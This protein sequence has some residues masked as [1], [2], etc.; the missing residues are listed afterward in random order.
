[1][2]RLQSLAAVLLAALAAVAPA[3]AQQAERQPLQVFLTCNTRCDLDFLRTEL[4]YLE[5][6]RDRADADVHVL[7]SDIET[8][9]GGEQY[10]LWFI[11]LGA[12]AGRTDTLSWFAE[13]TATD[14]DIRRGVLGQ[15][16]LGLVPYLVDAGWGPHL[17]LAVDAPAVA[18]AP[19]D[20]PWNA[21]VFN[22]TGETELEGESSFFAGQLYAGVSARR[23]T[24]A[25]KVSL[26]FNNRYE[27]ER[28]DVDSVTTVTSV[29][30]NWGV[31]GLAVRS[32][33]PHWA[34]GML[35]SLRSDS[36]D[37]LELSYGAAPA[38]EYNLYPYNDYTT[39]Y[40]TVLYTI[41]VNRADYE[42]ITVYDKLQETLVRHTLTAAVGVNQPWGDVRV[43]AEALQYFHDLAR[44]RLVVSGGTEINL[45]RGLSLD[46]GGDF[47]WIAD[48]IS[49][50]KR[51]LSEEE[52]LLRGG[53]LATDFNYDLRI[54]LSYS[55]G[56]RSNRAVNPR[57]DRTPGDGGYV[58]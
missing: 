16:Q 23:I 38:I 22:I 19:P 35:G 52:I 20:D 25:W 9:G 43:S 15:L 27:E 40:L 37:N 49:L 21:W 4:D 34:V 12:F 53:R 44:R 50:R 24:E 32:M 48:Q 45:F 36:Y 7:I 33:S 28:F 8:G 1:M 31:R 57:F 5:W 14:D 18:A 55:F 3:A 10:E 26:A 17:R 41:G 29:R 11:G 6:M 54:G 2:Y 46:M 39:R 30:R 42:E 51:E 47:S 58:F 13:A 56:S